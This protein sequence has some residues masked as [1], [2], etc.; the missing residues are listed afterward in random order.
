MWPIKT[1]GGA[2]TSARIRGARMASVLGACSPKAMCRNVTRHRAATGTMPTEQ[3]E[4]PVENRAQPTQTVIDQRKLRQLF[5]RRGNQR[6]DPVL[7]RPAQR[8]TGDRDPDL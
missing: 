4:E 1:R 8:Q 7:D 2:F 3:P 5:E 6:L